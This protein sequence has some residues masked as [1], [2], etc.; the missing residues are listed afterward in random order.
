MIAT[1][2]IF[3]ILNHLCDGNCIVFADSAEE[4]GCCLD[5]SGFTPFT[6]I[7]GVETPGNALSTRVFFNK[8]M[9]NSDRLY[10]EN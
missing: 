4:L 8:S 1:V 10:V 5:V 6:F 7:N 9:A 2:H 3:A